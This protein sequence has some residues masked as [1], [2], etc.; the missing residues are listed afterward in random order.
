MSSQLT[1]GEL[2]RRDTDPSA[3]TGQQ[4][5]AHSEGQLAPSL[6]AQPQHPAAGPSSAQDCHDEP[7]EFEAGPKRKRKGSEEPDKRK[8]SGRY[9]VDFSKVPDVEKPHFE[10]EGSEVICKP[11][12]WKNEQKGRR[13]NAAKAV[14]LVNTRDN[15]NSHLGTKSRTNKKAGSQSVHQHN[16]QEW[17]EHLERQAVLQ[18][19]PSSGITA[20]LQAAQTRGFQQKLVQFMAVFHALM[21]QRP[22]VAYEELRELLLVYRECDL[23][24]DLTWTD[25]SGWEIA[26]AL[27][28]EV[29]RCFAAA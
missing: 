28:L 9:K 1:L 22:M 26:E 20:G 19:Q 18:Q 24:G 10:V 4:H 8:C 5:S 11:C 29:R 2:W 25:N 3:A 6:G 13:G 27:A 21:H 12:T 16:T 17:K 14:V 7:E 23:I 15:V